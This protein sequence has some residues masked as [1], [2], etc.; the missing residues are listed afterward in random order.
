MNVQITELDRNQ[1]ADSI[2]VQ[3][4]STSAYI[5]REHRGGRVNVLCRNASHRVGRGAGRFFDDFDAAAAGYKSGAMKAAIEAARKELEPKTDD[6]Q[7]TVTVVKAD[8]SL[9]RPSGPMLRDEAKDERRRLM[10]DLDN[11]VYNVL[12]T[13]AAPPASDRCETCG[14]AGELPGGGPGEIRPCTDCQAPSQGDQAPRRPTAKTLR[15]QVVAE[16]SSL[17]LPDGLRLVEPSAELFDRAS[18]FTSHVPDLR[19]EQ[20]RLEY[21]AVVRHLAEICGDEL[22]Q[23][24]LERLSCAWGSWLAAS[25]RCAS[26]MVTGPSNFPIRR[27]RKASD[28][29]DRR[30]QELV[31]VRKRIVKRCAKAAK[32]AEVDAAGGPVAVLRQEIA[33][34]EAWRE[35]AKAANRIVKAKPK[36]ERTDAKIEKLVTLG[37][38]RPQA[39]ALFAKDFCGR[40]GF[41]DYELTNSLARLK[42]KRERLDELEKREAAA[43]NPDE[44]YVFDGVTITLNYEDDRV[45]IRYAEIPLGAVRKAMKASG[46]RFSRRNDNA[47]QRQLTAAARYS[48]RE[49]ARLTDP[50]ITI[51]GQAHGEEVSLEQH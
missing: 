47:W 37:V 48:A 49:I 12:L 32:T 38:E 42:A 1:Y 31:E 28:S 13:P 15:E 27:A 33:D 4:N 21:L 16:R 17:S 25:G 10:K 46:W 29:A 45:Q 9:G 41:A 35:M 44:E 3:V 50:T 5:S 11:G 26:S 8:R 39:E 22:G 6:D 18:S 34:L 51:R 30:Y 14:N 36:N 43:G 23:G 19:A 7:V 24:D 20:H 2:S 40:Y